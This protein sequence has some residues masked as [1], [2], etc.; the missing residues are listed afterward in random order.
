MDRLEAC[1]G[2]TQ[3]LFDVSLEVSEGDLVALVGANAAGKTTTLSCIAGLLKPSGGRIWF[4]GRDVTGFGADQMVELGVVYVPEGRRLFPRLTVRQNLL[5]GAYNRRA[6]P[7][8]AKNLAEVYEIFPILAER[9]HQLAGTLSG[10]EQQMCAIARGLMAMPR[11]LLLDEVSLGLAPITI[12]RVFDAIRTI[13]DRG[14]TILL[15][16]QNVANALK[17]ADYAYVLRNGSVVMSG[18]G[19]ELINNEQL[20]VAYL[21]G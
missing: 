13:R 21:G 5:L 10:G 16:E 19:E 17:L 14:T 4:D 20:R 9:Q 7:H 1:Y 15:V 6:R 12:S 18:R 11:L 3:V 2:D 8:L